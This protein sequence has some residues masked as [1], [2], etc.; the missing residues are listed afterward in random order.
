VFTLLS[1]QKSEITGELTKER[2]LFLGALRLNPGSCCVLPLSLIK[3][4]FSCKI[5]SLIWVQRYPIGDLGAR[6]F[7]G[8]LKRLPFSAAERRKLLGNL[9]K[10]SGRFR[11]VCD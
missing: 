6:T 8:V 5:F 11:E 9:L 1:G 10:E 2:K 7:S 3:F 4:C